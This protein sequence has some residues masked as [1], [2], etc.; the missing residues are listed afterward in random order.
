MKALK[1][2]YA[3]TFCSGFKSVAANN[4]IIAFQYV[5]LHGIRSLGAL[6]DPTFS[7]D[8]SEIFDIMLLW[9]NAISALELK[10]LIYFSQ[11][12]FK[13]V[14]KLPRACVQI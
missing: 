9:S 1:G 8:I 3:L 13:Q 10:W 4:I 11:Y 5:V 2:R 12:L 14:N 6:L 7:R